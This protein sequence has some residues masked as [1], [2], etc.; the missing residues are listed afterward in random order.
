MPMI[1]LVADIQAGEPVLGPDAAERLGSLGITRIALLRDL[2]S[3]AVVLEGWA[4]DPAR[5]DEATRA[6]FPAGGASLRTFHDV[7][8]VGVSTPR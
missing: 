7:E 8:Y 3:T 4:F 2:S 5:T 1:M 6:V